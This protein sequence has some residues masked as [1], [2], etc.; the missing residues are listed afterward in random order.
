M[1]KRWFAWF[2][3]WPNLVALTAC[4]FIV[5]LYVTNDDMGGDPHA[6]RGD[7]VYRPVLARGDGHMQYLMA[8]STALDFDWVFDNDLARFG[9][10][11][12]EPRTK[13]G[14]KAIIQ[15]IGAP[16]VWTPMI[17]TAQ[18]GAYVAN[19]FGADIPLHGYTLW[20]QRFVFLSSALFGCGAVLLGRRLAKQTIG[21]RWAGTYAAVAILLGT[22]I[23]FYATYMPSYSHAVDAFACAAFLAYW[24]HSIGRRDLRRWC[25]LGVLLGIAMLIRVQELAMGLVVAIEVGVECY[26]AIRTKDAPKH[27]AVLRWIGGGALVLAVA[28]IV[29]IPQLLEWHYVFGDAFGLPQGKRYTRP[30]APMVM[31]L[32]FSR[33]NGWFSTTPLAYLGVIGLFV[34]PRRAR[35]V[36]IGMLAVVAIQVYLNSTVLDWWGSSAFGQRRMCNATLPLVFG[37]ACLVVQCG[38]IVAR[39]SRFPLAMW[40]VPLLLF[41]SP[42]V[43][44]NYNHLDKLGK[45]RAAE[46]ELDTRCC[47]NVPRPFRKTAQRIADTIGSPFEF[48]ANA[49][50]ALRHGV[51]LKTWGHTGDYPLVGDMADMRDDRRLWRH[52]G[53]WRVASNHRAPYLV[54]GWSAP[55]EADRAL[56]YTTSPRVTVLIPNLM[57]YGQRVT[58]W[59]A[60]A[61]AT[62]AVLEWNGD[63]VAEVDL[64]QGW[65]AVHLDLPEIEVHTNE[66]SIVATPA[67]F[68]ATGW[69]ESPV[70]VGVAVGDLELEFLAG[71]A[72]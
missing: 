28:L 60:P 42:C 58:V 39:W 34:V 31:E 48:P 38:R 23:T 43:A 69:P 63:R 37:L 50:F 6:P 30:E 64:Q 67:P 71:L 24:A 4:C 46:S 61:G 10:P 22:P 40:H 36:G 7:G 9:D 47:A 1:S 44:T 21:G 32:L 25:I 11:W 49:I 52:R 72:R 17:W 12:R 35:L 41:I 8:R 59:L 33:R 5:G 45:G 54:G 29:F 66:L 57:P 53:A 27:P 16:L 3:Q 15:P 65:N 51:S 13:T 62:H 14:R 70:P 20:H 18:A 56:R 26:R 2:R 68:S 19:V 55:L